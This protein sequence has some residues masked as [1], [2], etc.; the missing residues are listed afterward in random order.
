MV[1]QISAGTILNTVLFT[2]VLMGVFVSGF[3]D[4]QRGITNAA[5]QVVII[6]LC[7]RF[8]WGDVIMIPK[9]TIAYEIDNNPKVKA[10][11]IRYTEKERDEALNGTVSAISCDNDG[12]EK[13][14]TMF[15]GIEET[16]FDLTEIEKVFSDNDE[17]LKAWEVGEAFAESYLTAH[18][19]CYFPWPDS[20][21]I[22]KPKSSLPGADHV[23]LYRTDNDV[24]FAFGE[25]KTSSESSYPP[26]VIKYG[27]HNLNKQ[28]KELRDNKQ[29]Q[30][31]LVKYLGYR[32]HNSSWQ[33]DYIKASTRWASS[34]CTDIKIFGVIVRDVFPH[35][36]DLKETYDI[37]SQN[38]PDNTEIK[39]LGLYMPEGSISNFVPTVTSSMEGKA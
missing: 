28:L 9:G 32:A 7:K 29:V 30:K 35:E 4:Q 11:G 39:L 34:S 31:Q 3:Q 5:K 17:T 1:E 21:D 2:S 33:G 37:V 22:R 36:N 6:S 12:T 16:G 18:H 23:G 24:C 25:V 20:R 13:L 14:R 19:N 8:P 15:A 10:K 27:E 26:H 38:K